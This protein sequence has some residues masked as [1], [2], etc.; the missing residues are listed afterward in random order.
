MAPPAARP[1]WSV[2]TLTEISHRRFTRGPRG[3]D[4]SHLDLA[5]RRPTTIGALFKANRIGSSA[6]T[7]T[8]L[9]NRLTAHASRPS[10]S[11]ETDSEEERPVLPLALR[12]PGS[13][14]AVVIGG[15]HPSPCLSD[16]GRHGGLRRRENEGHSRDLTFHVK[17]Q[18][19]GRC[20]TGRN[21]MSTCVARVRL[22]QQR[23]LL[24]VGRM[25]NVRREMP[26]RGYGSAR[27][28]G[29]SRGSMQE[30]HRTWR[31]A[32]VRSG[33]QSGHA[34]RDRWIS[35][36]PSAAPMPRKVGR[37]VSRGTATIALDVFGE[38]GRRCR[39]RRD[40]DAGWW[41]AGRLT[42]MRA[43]VCAL[44]GQSSTAPRASTRRHTLCTLRAR[45]CN[46]CT[47]QCDPV[48]RSAATQ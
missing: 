7:H 40:E 31:Q 17:P 4:P 44:V 1:G 10:S 45:V 12:R 15:P 42:A 30:P 38:D 33:Q 46:V 6:V 16:T 13:L 35:P 37:D 27:M 8:A 29:V 32:G 47:I 19:R 26:P 18:A 22:Q 2:L 34:A 23:S 5:T 41:T 36:R 48:V 3:I 28:N 14:P 25:A 39:R 9:W 11:D 20:V 24:A 21:T 43:S